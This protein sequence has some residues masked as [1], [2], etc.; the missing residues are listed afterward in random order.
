[1][2]DALLLRVGGGGI[3][4]AVAGDDAAVFAVPVDPAPVA[5]NLIAQ[6]KTLPDGVKIYGLEGPRRRSAWTREWG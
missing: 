1:M 5:Y 3:A 2:L 4:I 6:R